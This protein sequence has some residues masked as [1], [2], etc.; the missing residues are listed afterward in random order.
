MHA[1][2]YVLNRT[3]DG[4]LYDRPVRQKTAYF[5]KLE[6]TRE[7]YREMIRKMHPEKPPATLAE[8][9]R[10]IKSF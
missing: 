5:Q 1:H 2:L 7:K 4:Y 9:F 6:K 10:D 8:G 3:D